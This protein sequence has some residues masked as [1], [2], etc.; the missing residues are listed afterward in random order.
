MN[1]VVLNQF[2]KYIGMTPFV[3]N[4]QYE[5]FCSGMNPMVVNQ[6]EICRSEIKK[7]NEEYR[8]SRL[9]LKNTDSK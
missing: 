4:N 2:E 3:I 5:I 1:T 9:I 6:C 7:V 8:I